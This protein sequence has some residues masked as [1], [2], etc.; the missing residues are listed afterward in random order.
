MFFFTI[1]PR[2]RGGVEKKWRGADISSSLSEAGLENTHHVLFK[3][4]FVG[5]KG[6]ERKGRVDLISIYLGE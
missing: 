6:E 5:V 1:K 4:S 3:A 2:R